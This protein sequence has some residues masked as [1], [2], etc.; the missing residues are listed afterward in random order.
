M[1]IA[2]VTQRHVRVTVRMDMLTTTYAG[3]DATLHASMETSNRT[4]LHTCDLFTHTQRKHVCT[5]ART[6][7]SHAYREACPK[8]EYKS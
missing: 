3:R 6:R 7:Y 4:C 2:Y 5:D 8:T 1:R